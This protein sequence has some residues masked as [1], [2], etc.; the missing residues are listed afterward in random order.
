MAALSVLLGTHNDLLDEFHESPADAF[1]KIFHL[2]IDV[3]SLILAE[4]NSILSIQRSCIVVYHASLGDY[5]FD[6]SRSGSF[7][8]DETQVW[9]DLFRYWL[10]ATEPHFR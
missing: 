10:S 3:A 4:L 6:R 5:L 8:I 1:S 9:T 7:W 2:D